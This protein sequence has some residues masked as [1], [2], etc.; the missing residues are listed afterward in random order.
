MRRSIQILGLILPTLSGFAL[1]DGDALNLFSDELT[2]ASIPMV[3]PANVTTTSN[4][5]LEYSTDM[6]N[7]TPVTPG[8]YAESAEDQFFRVRVI[9][10]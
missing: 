3:L 4:V 8:S 9:V 6:V 5:V 1:Q 2:I 7:W 10:D